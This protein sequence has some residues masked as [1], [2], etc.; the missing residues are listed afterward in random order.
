MAINDFISLFYVPILWL[1]FNQFQ[2]LGTGSYM[3]FNSFCSILF[4]ILAILL[5]ILYLYMWWKRESE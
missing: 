2:D 5:P 1:A 4:L 3:I